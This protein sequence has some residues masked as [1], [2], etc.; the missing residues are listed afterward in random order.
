MTSNTPNRQPEGTPVGGEFATNNRTEA[1]VSLTP[2]GRTAFGGYEMR[3]Y[4][5]VGQGMEGRI[6]SATIYRDGK[7]V[8]TVLDEGNG[9]DMRFTSKVT[10]YAHQSAELDA[11]RNQAALFHPDDAAYGAEGMLAET[12]QF[13]SELDKLAKRHGIPRDVVVRD[14]V[15]AGVITEAEFDLFANPDSFGRAE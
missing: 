3:N 4:R 6:W 11:F 12:L 9:G 7:A 10:G 2:P 5:T 8:L 14:H 15:D 13:S 1:A